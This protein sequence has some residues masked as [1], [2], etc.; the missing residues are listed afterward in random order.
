ME[1]NAALGTNAVKIDYKLFAE[2]DRYPTGAI[3]IAF[4]AQQILVEPR[5]IT[6][7]KVAIKSCIRNIL[8]NNISPLVAYWNMLL[9]VW[10]Q[11]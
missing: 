6:F 8:L 9:H 7:A 5:Y 1:E 4:A 11:L 10:I 3:C 2:V